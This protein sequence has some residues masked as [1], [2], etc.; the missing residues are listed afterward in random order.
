MDAA[1]RLMSAAALLLRV[2]DSGGQY[3][4]LTP[5]VPACCPASVH[6]FV[7]VHRMHRSP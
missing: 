5:Q 6:A 1:N 7:A 3:V 4:L 2:A